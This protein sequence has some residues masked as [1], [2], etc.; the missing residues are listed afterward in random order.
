MNKLE[1]LAKSQP[2]GW[3]CVATCFTMC[4]ADAA[5]PV[6]DV[7]GYALGYVSANA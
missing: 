6:V 1:T 5:S 2:N 4:L 3:R 7:A